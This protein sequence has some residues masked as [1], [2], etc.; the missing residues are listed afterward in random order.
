M[1]GNTNKDEDDG[2][3]I[4][5]L[6]EKPLRSRPVAIFDTLVK[7]VSADCKYEFDKWN[8]KDPMRITKRRSESYKKAR[9][10]F[11][12]FCCCYGLAG[13]LT[14]CFGLILIF[15]ALQEKH[16]ELDWHGPEHHPGDPGNVLE[17]N[18]DD[19]YSAYKKPT[20]LSETIKYFLY[21]DEGF[22]D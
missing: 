9:Q 20:S 21:G 12:C 4:V 13:I 17:S 8:G 22:D 5:S 15:D 11:L 2:P 14:V 7:D 19:H 6:Y 3:I 16:D 10:E 18:T 1:T